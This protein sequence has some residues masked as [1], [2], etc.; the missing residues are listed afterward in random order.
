MRYLTMFLISKLCS[1][2]K[3]LYDQCN[4]TATTERRSFDVAGKIA[5]ALWRHGQRRNGKMPTLGLA[6]LCLLLQNS[7]RIPRARS[8]SRIERSRTRLPV[9]LRSLMCEKMFSEFKHVFGISGVLCQGRGGGAR[10]SIKSYSFGLIMKNG[11]INP[12]ISKII[13]KSEVFLPGTDDPLSGN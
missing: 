6:L 12:K 11:H 4:A 9:G 13:Q 5:F 2:F 3:T 8:P 10:C 7:A 1:M